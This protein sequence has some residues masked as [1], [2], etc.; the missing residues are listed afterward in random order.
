MQSIRWTLPL[1]LV[2]CIGGFL[3]SCTKRDVP[4]NNANTF[5]LATGVSLTEVKVCSETPKRGLSVRKSNSDFLITAAG[6]FACDAEIQAPYLSLTREKKATLV[7]DSKA[8]KSDCECFTTVTV[9][10]SD[11]LEAGDTLY[12]SNDGEVLGHVVMP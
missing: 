1:A 7:I 8:T 12:V 11:R 4:E 9:K 3:S 2:I 6:T 10:L 5:T